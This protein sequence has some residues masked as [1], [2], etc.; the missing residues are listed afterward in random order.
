[1]SCISETKL[2][3]LISSGVDSEYARE[4]IHKW[5]KEMKIEI[6]K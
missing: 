2:F 6:A 4:L 5:A 3:E 1:M